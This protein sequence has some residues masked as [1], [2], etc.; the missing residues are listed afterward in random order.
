M[1]KHNSEKKHDLNDEKK[2]R[3]KTLP[4]I[5]KWVP[6][7]I[8]GVVSISVPIIV[9]ITLNMVSQVWQIIIVAIAV[10][11]F[12]IICGG[13]WIVTAVCNARTIEKEAY[14][15]A[16]EDLI[17]NISELDKQKGALSYATDSLIGATNNL[18]K[19]TTEFVKSNDLFEQILDGEHIAELEAS[20]GSYNS[21]SK[22]LDIYILASSFTL[23]LSN[24]VGA[25]LEPIIW[26]LR[27]GVTY[28]YLIPDQEASINKY[29]KMLHSWYQQYSVFLESK[30]DFDEFYEKYKSKNNKY[31]QFWSDAYE[32]LVKD[33]EK[34]WNNS[35]GN[36]EDLKVRCKKL[37]QE[38]IIT[39]VEEPSLFFVTAAAYEN[40]H[41][42][43]DA[44]I[45]IPT[46]NPNEKYY[47]LKV[48]KTQIENFM[49]QFMS[50]YKI[51]IAFKD[52]TGKHY[53]GKYTLDENIFN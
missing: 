14:D 31:S 39:H 51:N 50:L 11:A 13:C 17:R 42:T 22:M 15:N 6:T 23:E 52:D 10:L 47:A 20:V 37:F 12:L 40:Q 7:L 27:K 3:L 29:K 24:G 43:F 36:L 1:E 48:S 53:G 19:T 46:E 32:Q 30:D 2:H 49:R 41:G 38:H 9:N 16:C 18:Y 35:Y 8:G 33:T 25:L 28:H 5:K 4:T 26:N 34:Y 44:I 45:K 21:H